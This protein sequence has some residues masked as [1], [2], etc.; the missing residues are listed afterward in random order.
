MYH[1][2]KLGRKEINPK[3]LSS[4]KKQELDKA[5]GKEWGKML[6]S[7]AIIVHEGDAAEELIKRYGKQRTLESRFMYTSDDG[8][9]SG[10]LKTRWCIKGFLDPD[11]LD[12]ATSSPTLSNEGLAVTLQLTSNGW[13][14]AIGDIEA[15]FLRGDDMRRP[16]GRVFVSSGRD[17]RVGKVLVW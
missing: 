6:A 17:P 11:V 7:G 14:L 12:V 3:R 16:K 2:R 13:E 9:P 10:V 8:T 4:Q 15:A 5:K 1:A